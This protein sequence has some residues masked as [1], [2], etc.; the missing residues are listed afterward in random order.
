MNDAGLEAL[1]TL[2]VLLA[3]GLLATLGSAVLH[4]HSATKRLEEA[5]KPDEKWRK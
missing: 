5:L 4:G 3:T 1:G 2:I